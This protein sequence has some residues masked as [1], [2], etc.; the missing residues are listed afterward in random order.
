[1]H[2][3]LFKIREN[4]YFGFINSRGEVAIAAQYLEAGE[5]R[6][7]LKARRSATVLLSTL[8]GA[9]LVAWALKDPSVIRPAAKQAIDSFA[10]PLD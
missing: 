1:M 2:Q 10:F 6:D 3:P 5:F 4:G 9:S 7:N 8:Q